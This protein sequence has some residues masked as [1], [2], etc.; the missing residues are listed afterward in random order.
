MKNH[1]IILAIIAL[2]LL[3]W[4]GYKNWGWFGGTRTSGSTTPS[5][6]PT[7]NG[8]SATGKTAT[9]HCSDCIDQFLMNLK[10]AAAPIV[11][12]QGQMTFL[13][14]PWNEYVSQ[15]KQCIANVSR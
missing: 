1:Y 3:G 12:S 14:T 5:S 10:G 6:T 9:L 4:Y 7:Q 8:S 15:L 13:V 2:A 11:P